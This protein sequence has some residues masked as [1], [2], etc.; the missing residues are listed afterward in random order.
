M[1][2]RGYVRTPHVPKYSDLR[3]LHTI[4]HSGFTPPQL[5]TQSATERSLRYPLVSIRR[6][7]VREAFYLPFLQAAMVTRFPPQIFFT[8]G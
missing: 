4:K 1:V 2:R 8:A 6:D 3:C 5:S 7:V